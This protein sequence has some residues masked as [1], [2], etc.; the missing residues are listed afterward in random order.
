MSF[1]LGPCV[2]GILYNLFHTLTILS[3]TVLP[4]LIWR[5]EKALSHRA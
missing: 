1:V 5:A 2:H 3:L 4:Y